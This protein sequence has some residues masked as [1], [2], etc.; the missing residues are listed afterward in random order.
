M[1]QAKKRGLFIVFEGLDRSGKSTQ[2]KKLAERLQGDFIC[3]PNRENCESGQLL[4]AYLKN[5]KDMG[6]ES[7]HLL[8]AMNRWE[9][10]NSIVQR[11]QDGQSV[12]CDRYAYS[13]VC[14]SSAKGLKFDWCLGADRGL[15]K[16]DLVFYID[17][18][19]NDIAKRAG[20]G[21]ERFEKIEFQ[22]KVEQQF[23]S[24]KQAGCSDSEFP[25]SDARHWV[26]IAATGLSI[27]EVESKI[28]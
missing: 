25:T 7:V 19:A 21:D 11:L 8:F 6:D 22:S 17:M 10:R 16:P 15:V 28:L 4:N 5:G 13:G 23:A 24:F 12:I 9:M 18:S 1:Q 27:E 2:A 3:F 20:F 26:N 14:Y